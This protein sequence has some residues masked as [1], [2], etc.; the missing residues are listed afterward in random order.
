MTT[1]QT[2]LAWTRR[3][4][5]A[6]CAA[7]PVVAMLSTASCASKQDVLVAP[8]VHIAPYDT[9]SGDVLWAVVPLRNESGTTLTDS[10][11]ISDKVVQAAAQVQGV[12][13][14]PLNRTIAAMRALHVTELQTPAD[15][16]KLASELGVDGLIVGSIT[17]WDPYDPPKLGLALALYSR[18][19]AMDRR[20][21][22]ALDTRALEAQP[23]DYHYFPRSAYESAPA[24]VVSEF[25][26]GKNHQVLMDVK[27][28]AAGRHD[29]A[30][31]LAWR[32]YL[33]SMDL[34]SEFAAWH[35]VG[36]L[37]DHEWIRL[38]QADARGNGK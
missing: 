13:V 3:I 4:R 2:M 37:L 30:T 35:A 6:L 5:R 32:R 29:A 14:L 1:E 27:T 15:A 7:A 31:A 12:R 9:A 24:S 19:G 21:A 18:P 33:A 22:R 16:K 26:D 25:L 8:Q 38:A 23:T 17:A 20:S 10:Y 28:Y 11:E 36:R 34:F